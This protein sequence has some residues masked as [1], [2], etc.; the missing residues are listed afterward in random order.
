MKPRSKTAQASSRGQREHS[1]GATRTASAP[2]RLFSG[3]AFSPLR[4]VLVSSLPG[5]L[6]ILPL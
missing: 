4:T 6:I 5:L 2:A 1:A 3:F